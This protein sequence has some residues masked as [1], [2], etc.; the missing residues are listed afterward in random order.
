MSNRLFITVLTANKRERER[1]KKNHA[2]TTRSKHT[3]TILPLGRPPPKAQSNVKQP[4]GKV[5]LYGRKKQISPTFNLHYDVL[6]SK[7]PGMIWVVGR[8]V[9][10]LYINACS[11]KGKV[12]G[13]K[14]FEIFT[15]NIDI[16]G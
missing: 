5:S 15:F 9:S 12:S 4:L 11:V 13:A 8:A 2:R 1:G 7:T 16:D 6:S 14:I 3:S 10:K